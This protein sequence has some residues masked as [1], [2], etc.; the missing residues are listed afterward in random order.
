LYHLKI[1]IT[2]KNAKVTI[3]NCLLSAL[4]PLFPDLA[5]LLKSSLGND[6]KQI[7]NLCF[8]KSKKNENTS[9]DNKNCF[10]NKYIKSIFLIFFGFKE[11]I[12]KFFSIY[13]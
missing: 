11:I 2:E 4:R 10:I 6:I 3:L 7:V 12:S 1:W 5:L 8:V 13:Q 9:N